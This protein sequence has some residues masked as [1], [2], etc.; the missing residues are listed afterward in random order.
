MGLSNPLKN[1]L[2]PLREIA[3]SALASDW[4]GSRH[5]GEK[6]S[7]TQLIMSLSLALPL[8]LLLTLNVHDFSFI[9]HVH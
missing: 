1:P 2:R 6:G 7:S 3:I 5:R 8:L 9:V 4:P